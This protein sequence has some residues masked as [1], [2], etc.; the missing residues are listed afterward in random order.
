MQRWVNGTSP[1]YGFAMRSANESNDQAGLA[2]VRMDDRSAVSPLDRIGL[3]ARRAA[4]PR[5]GGGR[6]AVG[7]PGSVAS[8]L[9][10]AERLP[11]ASGSVASALF[12]RPHNPSDDCSQK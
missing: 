5:C 4:A 1:N 3:A 11:R 8:A 12:A 7:T 9:S 10:K 2:F 6:P